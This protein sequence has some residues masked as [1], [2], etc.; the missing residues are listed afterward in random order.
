MLDHHHDVRTVLVADRLTDL[1]ASYEP[2]RPLRLR[3]GLRLVALG[4][5]LARPYAPGR[6]TVARVR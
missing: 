4:E 3:I 6:V 2:G 5:R 1:A